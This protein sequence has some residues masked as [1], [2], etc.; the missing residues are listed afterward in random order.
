MEQKRHSSSVWSEIEP[1]CLLRMLAR[2]LWMIL[3]AAVSFSLLAY[4]AVTLLLKPTYTSSI[5]FAVTPKNTLS[6]G[7]I[8]VSASTAEQFSSLLSSS[9]FTKQIQHE[10]GAAVSGV[11][12]SASP[13]EDTNVIRVDAVGSTP[14]SVYYMASGIVENYREWTGGFFTAV[15]L[16]VV[17]APNIPDNSAFLARQQQI[18]KIAAPV[19]ALLM[20]GVLALLCITSGTVQTTV[21]ARSQVD[22]NLLVTVRHERRRRTLKSWLTKKKPSLLISNPT[23]A[24][25]YVETVHQL[26]AKIEHANRHHGCKSFLITS[27]SENEGKSTLAANL[28]LSLAKRYK[29]VLLVD[30]DL[31]KASQNHILG[32]KHEAGKSLNSLL[33][34]DLDPSALVR[35][36]Q[37]RKA[38][39]LFC[40]LA[41][42]M[43][44]GTSALLGSQQMRQILKVLRENFDYVI[45]DTPPMG[46]FTDSEILADA[47]DA[48]LLVLRQDKVTDLAAN[49]TIDALRRCKARFLGYVFN[50]VHTLNLF[51]KL[52]GGRR[53]YG[54]GYSSDYGYGYGKG[55]YSKYGYGYG[56]GSHYGKNK[57][58][59]EAASSD[60]KKEEN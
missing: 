19:G 3:M 18:V 52:V 60:G 36:L 37:Y 24:F 51:S 53:G 25:S 2:N 35:T 44:H 40:L 38:D 45:V 20:A 26:R 32:M 42:P 46:Y 15:V 33:K 59:I 16:E 5:T 56:Y 58:R 31:R 39:N 49:D 22:G 11:T 47:A 10:Y 21:G 34:G 54:Y 43:R 14:S 41:A 57:E 23:T 9:L 7:N 50:D 48:S 13:I 8:T 28:A 6:S 4:I 12:V 17:N 30:C 29:K 1:Y 55:S 27:V